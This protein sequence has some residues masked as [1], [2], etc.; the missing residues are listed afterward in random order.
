MSLEVCKKCVDEQKKLYKCSKCSQ[1]LCMHHYR[2]HK[3]SDPN[4]GLRG[5]RSARLNAF[6][7][8]NAW[9]A[10]I[11]K[12]K[13]FKLEIRDDFSFIVDFPWYPFTQ[14]KAWV[15]ATRENYPEE[16]KFPL[17][18]DLYLE[19]L[20]NKLVVNEYARKFESSKWL[21]GKIQ[22]WRISWLES[23]NYWERPVTQR[24]TKFELLIPQFLQQDLHNLE[25]AGCHIVLS[26]LAR[27][28]IQN[29]Q[30]T[31]LKDLNIKILHSPESM[32][33]SWSE[34]A[35]QWCRSLIEI[36]IDFM[37]I[38]YLES[39][40]EWKW[41]VSINHDKPN[42]LSI[43]FWAKSR[44]FMFWDA[45]HHEMKQAKIPIVNIII[46]QKPENLPPLSKIHP[47]NNYSLR[48]YQQKAIN[49]W[50]ENFYFGSEQLPTGAGKTIIG[51]DAIY[52]SKTPALILV[53]N[54][55][56]IEQWKSRIHTYLTIPNELIGIFSGQHKTFEDYDIVISTY[57]LLS[58]YIKD[59]YLGTQLNE[60]S[61]ITTKED[62]QKKPFSSSNDD[63]NDEDDQNEN[64]DKK[65]QELEFLPNPTKP[66][67]DLAIVSKT[68]AIFQ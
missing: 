14:L 41:I 7:T 40:N 26:P 39:P 9:D 45:A 56:L 18:L 49:I 35:D 61:N 36:F 62:E 34:K 2:T 63:E 30:K 53:P 43:P 37:T 44:A 5:E 27:K 50:S 8:K 32:K 52:R 12:T 20:T 19:G 64:G 10:Q 24:T 15:P 46:E 4:L 59:Y 66:L 67:R 6:V 22:G 48:P 65:D 58:Q 29:I 68:L 42:E 3:C 21:M 33:I 17:D 47:K 38:F 16:E 1:T 23:P 51:I 57:Q 11:K 55:D 54:L 28:N 60:N 13:S 31:A 25:K